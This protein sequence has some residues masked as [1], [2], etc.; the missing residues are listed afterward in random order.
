MRWQEE[1]REE[2]KD[3]LRALSMET[4]FEDEDEGD[5]E[6]ESEDD[7]IDIEEQ[8]GIDDMFEGQ[9]QPVV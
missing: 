1:R 3:R 4:G 8:D 6:I 2:M 5:E 9:M 7:E